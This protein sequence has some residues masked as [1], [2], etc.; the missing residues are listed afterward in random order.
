M[1][2]AKRLFKPVRKHIELN[3]IKPRRAVSKL[4]RAISLLVLVGLLTIAIAVAIKG[5]S[6]NVTSYMLSLTAQADVSS[7]AKVQLKFPE[8]VDG[9]WKRGKIETYTADNLYEKIDG[10]AEL[11]ISYDVA[12]LICTSYKPGGSK[13]DEL[14]IDVFVYDMGNPLNAFGIYSYERVSGVGKPMKLG[15]G[16]YQAAGS[17]YFWKGRHYVQIV[18]PVEDAKLKGI[19]ERLAK[20]I[21]AQLKGEPA[22]LWGL[23]VF[24]KDGLVHDSITYIKRKAFGHDFL[25]NVWTTQYRRGGKL[26]KAFMSKRQSAHDAKARLL[27]WKDTVSKYGRVLSQKGS[28]EQLWLVGKVGDRYVVVFCKGS[29]LGGVV[30]A[31]D[32]KVAE[33]FARWLFSGIK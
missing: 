27:K 11:Y 16:G 29:L 4:E 31:D 28:G 6:S 33:G 21:E 18:T 20:S 32:A 12:G 19:C 10:R 2:W 26:L 8:V 3:R 14:F 13:G 5:R 9:E 15:E 1:S 7:S 17:I 23:K 25:D 22:D 30:E 24:P